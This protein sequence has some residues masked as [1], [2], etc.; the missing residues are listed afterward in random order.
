ML[1]ALSQNKSLHSVFQTGLAGTAEGDDL[2][3]LKLYDQRELRQLSE[4]VLKLK[5]DKLIRSSTASKKTRAKRK[6][7][8]VYSQLKKSLDWRYHFGDTYKLPAKNSVTQL[9]HNSDEYVKVD[10]SRA[11]DRQPCALVSAKPVLIETVEPRLIGTATHLVISQLDLTAALT[12]ET[13]EKTKDKLIAGNCFTPSVAEHID[14]ESILAFFQ[15]EPGRLV[16]DDENTVLREWP[17]TFAL[18][19][20]E[21]N[22]SCL[23][24]DTQYAIRD[25]IIVQGIIDMLIRTPQGLVI[26][27]FKTDCVTPGQVTQRAE[28]Y[29]RQLDYY[30]RATSAVL[31]S[32]S[33]TKWLYFLIPR[34]SKE[35]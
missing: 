2:F 30:S 3:S 23:I 33:I 15:S 27:D 9:T 11:L 10:Y 14:T 32:E 6:E 29:R 8:K 18:P 16:S 22:D 5:T 1:Y 31:K 20:S 35:V 17:F 26:I 7:S 19:A 4:F 28:L 24:R 13:V 34:I 25:T 21:W 12:A